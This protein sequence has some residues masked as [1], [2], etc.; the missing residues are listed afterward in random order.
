I[1]GGNVFDGPSAEA[2]HQQL[3]KRLE[4]LAAL[5]KLVQSGFELAHIINGN[6]GAQRAANRLRR[7]PQHQRSWSLLGFRRLLFLVGVVVVVVVVTLFVVVVVAVLVFAILF[8]ALVVIAIFVLTD[9]GVVVAVVFTFLVDLFLV[10][11]SVDVTFLFFLLV[12]VFLLVF[13]RRR[14]DLGNVVGVADQRWQQAEQPA[15][16]LAPRLLGRVGLLA[17]KVA[18][19]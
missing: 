16:A 3:I 15:P 11:P 14:L 6:S 2:S 1:A 9:F 12:L 7:L 4:Q 8:V 10:G 5:G 19:L 13:L 17:G 18:V